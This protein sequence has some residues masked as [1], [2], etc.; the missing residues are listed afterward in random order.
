MTDE[1][2]SLQVAVVSGSPADRD[3]LRQAAAASKVPIEVIEA[4]GVTSAGRSLAAGVD[5]VLVDAALGS[6]T[7]G[8]V[9][10]AARA[11]PKPP[12]TVLLSPPGSG[13][14]FPTDALAAKPSELEEAKEFI[15]RAVRVRL[16]TRVLILDDS[17]T[18]RSIVRKI[19]A[20]TRFPLELSEV[21]QGSEAIELARKVDFDIVFFDYNLPGFSGL[22]TLAEFRRERRNPT[23]VLITSAQDATLATRARSHG[24][25]FLKK[26]FFPADIEAILCGFYGLRAVNPQR[27]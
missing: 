2:L 27:A 20:G 4:D 13:V 14:P 6:E 25:T 21:E 9:A 19:L 11:R 23:F 26:P 1:L 12:F 8:Q 24:A 3:L 15:D 16:P 5:L 10:S 7:V 17:A 18:M 22:E